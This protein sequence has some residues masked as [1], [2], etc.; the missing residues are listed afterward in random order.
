MK[1]FENVAWVLLFI[2]ILYLVCKP[3]FEGWIES[4]K[5]DSNKIDIRDGDWINSFKNSSCIVHLQSD[6]ISDDCDIENKKEFTI[7]EL[8][9][10]LQLVHTKRNTIDFNCALGKKQLKRTETITDKILHNIKLI[11]K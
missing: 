3:Y 1:N 7:S 11:I 9:F 10:I 5:C 4:F 6:I 2:Y 8:R